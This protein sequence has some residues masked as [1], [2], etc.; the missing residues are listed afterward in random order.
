MD[1]TMELM[2]QTTNLPLV[3]CKNWASRYNKHLQTCYYWNSTLFPDFTSELFNSEL[4]DAKAA[5]SGR[6]KVLRFTEAGQAY[7][8]R[9]FHRGGWVRCISNDLYLLPPHLPTR[10]EAEVG[11]LLKLREQSLPVPEPAAYRIQRVGLLCRMDLILKEISGASNLVEILRAREI[12][13]DVWQQIGKTIREF[14]SAG[15]CHSD[16]N[17]HNIL[18]DTENKVWLVDF[19][20]SCL[21]KQ[22]PR[23]WRAQNLARLRRSLRKEFARNDTFYWSENDW[24]QLLIGY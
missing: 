2:E 24:Q 8:L 3:N 11:L 16:L 5:G 22:F 20:K 14:H 17:A 13:Q 1:L 4:K 21:I 23:V 10:V 9:H 19:D 6:G 12:G 18:L 7:V 15:V